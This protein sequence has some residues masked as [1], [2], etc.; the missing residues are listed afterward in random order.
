MA[1]KERED[2]R[3][4]QQQ[5]DRLRLL[6]APSA[7]VI[8]P[9]GSVDNDLDS[10]DLDSMDVES[11]MTYSDADCEDKSEDESESEGFGFKADFN[12]DDAQ[13]MDLDDDLDKHIERFVKLKYT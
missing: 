2:A 5:L 6:P 9:A 12:T 8:N 10:K 1:A 4:R 11:D 3:E 7:S 13:A